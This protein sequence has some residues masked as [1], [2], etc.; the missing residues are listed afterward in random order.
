MWSCTSQRT[1]I[2]PFVLNSPLFDSPFGYLP[3]SKRSAFEYEK[4]LWKTSSPFG[5][6]T[7]DPTGTATMRGRNSIPS[8]LIS[9]LRG[10][11]L[12]TAAP[13]SQT[14]AGEGSGLVGPETPGP[15]YLIFCRS[16]FWA[17]PSFQETFPATLP[18]SSGAQRRSR[19]RQSLMTEDFTPPSWTLQG[20]S[21]IQLDF[22]VRPAQE[23]LPGLPPV[24]GRDL[25]QG[26]PGRLPRRL[27]QL[28]PHLG[29]RPVGL[30][31]CALHAG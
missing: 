8:C 16:F 9:T 12:T 6:F 17:G 13:S 23:H 11:I 26:L 15:A 25:H 4:T 22:P 5:N 3:R 10:S 19:A 30:A 29:G 28:Q 31:L 18:A 21:R 1:S 20:G 14:T 7:V 27:S 24:A 2:R